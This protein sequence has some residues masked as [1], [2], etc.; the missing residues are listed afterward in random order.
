MLFVLCLHLRED[1]SFPRGL[2]E[3]LSNH[4]DDGYESSDF[5][6]KLG[7][8]AN[9]SH[10]LVFVYIT[11]SSPHLFPIHAASLSESSKNLERFFLIPSSKTSN[12]ILE[13]ASSMNDEE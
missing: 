3:A 5:E 13:E 8:Y 1:Q 9:Y 11:E 10:Q 6:S 7:E 4:S 12:L 2:L